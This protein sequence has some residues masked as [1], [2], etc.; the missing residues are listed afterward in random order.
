MT[1][2]TSGYTVGPNE[3]LT[4]ARILY[5]PIAGT[6]TA[7]GADGGLAANDYTNQRWTAGTLPANWTLVTG[8]NA[9]VD[10]VFIAAHNLGSTGSTVAVQTA[11]TVGGAFTT[12]ATVTPTDDSTIAVMIN[13]GSAPYV[14]R[15][16]RIAVTGSS[17][18]VQVGI[19]RAGVALQMERA[20]FGGV[21]PLGLNRVVETRQS[22]SETGQWLGRTVQMQ[23]QRTSM[24]W[25]HLSSTWYRANFQPFALSLPH[26]PF[27]LIQNPLRM[28]E[29]VG[30]CWTDQSPSPS[31][32]GVR[33]MMSVQLDIT[34]FIG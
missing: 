17:G 8:A 31:N 4:H 34:G 26:Q 29:S 3:P 6:I 13:S 28:P 19:I 22:I 9:E 2:S 11:A 18:D 16:I 20:V 27:G 14:I 15:E 1:L 5:A 32:M 7:D 21:T 12:R 25:Q 10:T 30:W 33:D 24:G 23:A